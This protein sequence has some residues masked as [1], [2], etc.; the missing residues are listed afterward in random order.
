[1]FAGDFKSPACVHILVEL[2]LSF[3]GIAGGES[4]EQAGH[5]ASLT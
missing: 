2:D 4:A 5:Q 1:M 3:G